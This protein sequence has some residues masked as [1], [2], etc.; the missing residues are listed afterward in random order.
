M[1]NARLFSR[2]FWRRAANGFALATVLAPIALMWPASAFAAAYATGGTSPYRQQVLWLT[3]G[4]GTN[5]T[6]GVA[7]G[8]GATS[9]ATV[10]VTP[11][12]NLVLTC[13]LANAGAAGSSGLESYRP[14]NYGGDALDDLYNIGGTGTANQLISG[15]MTRASTRSFRVSCTSTIGGQPFRVPGLVMADAESMNTGGTIE[16]PAEILQ[17]SAL[18]TW[19]V[20]EMNRVAGRTYYARKTAGAGGLETIRFGPGGEG[21]GTSPAAVTFLSFG[22]NAYSGGNFQV[23]VDF[24]IRGGGNTAIAIGMLV[25]YADFGDAPT[26]YGAASHLIQTLDVTPDGLPA[27]G[28]S[29]DI[30]AASFQLGRLATNQNFFIGSQGPDAESTSAHS[31]DARGDD[32]AGIAGPNEE[33][34]LPANTVIFQH[35]I[36]EVFTRNIACRGNGTLAGWIDFNRNGTFDAAERAQGVCNGTSA[37][38]SWT[39]P[40]NLSVGRTFA[41]LRYASDPAEIALP[42][43]TARDGEVED[44]AIEVQIRADVFV[45][46]AV[47]PGTVRNGGEA[48]YTLTVGNNG[49]SSVSGTLLRD[50]PVTGLDC[51]AAVPTCTATAGAVCPTDLSIGALQG[52]GMVIPTL[53]LGGEV[54]VALTCRVT[55]SGV[56]P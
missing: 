24:Q 13:A 11:G 9:T 33:D 56:A 29:V 3:W 39:I 15:I 31:P 41:R 16:T 28:V 42:T 4:G 55:A 40:T 18:G 22:S 35:Q 50:P 54:R 21:G 46:K 27:N 19:N 48:T 7:V 36:G 5:G 44:H 32:S 8:D 43:G 1:R 51:S 10:E 45:T 25:P 14:G 38:L 12:Q 53:P 37:P 52:T 2:N 26:S 20:V 30:N 34:G 49:E 6:N 17:A 47:S 23:G